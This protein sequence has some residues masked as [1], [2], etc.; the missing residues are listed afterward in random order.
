M[1]TYQIEV[2]AVVRKTFTVEAEDIQEAKSNALFE[3]YSDKQYKKLQA[4]DHLATKA[5]VTEIIDL[6]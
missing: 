1:K 2:V 5:T 6:H 3:A 4:T